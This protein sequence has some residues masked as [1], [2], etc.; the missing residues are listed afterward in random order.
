MPIPA[1]GLVPLDDRPCNRL[2]PTQL[3]GLVGLEVTLP[4]RESLGWFTQPGDS[5]AV[6]AWV[7]QC[8][9]QH[10]VLSLDMLCYGGL[11]AARS[12]HT[13]PAA[14]NARL[15]G[16]RALKQQRPDLV[17]YA[18]NCLPRLGLTVASAGDLRAHEDLIAYAMLADRVERLGEDEARPE[19]EAVT[20]R[21]DP[22][23]LASYLGVR[24]RNHEVSR[25]ALQLTADGVFD[26]LALVQEDAAPVGLHMGEQEALRAEVERLG[27]GDRVAIHP[28]ADEVGLVLMARHCNLNAGR[29]ARVCADYATEAGSKVIPL[30]EDRPLRETVLSTL[31]AAGAEAAPPMRADAILFVHTPIGAQHESIEAPP[32]GQSPTVAMQADSVAERIGFAAEAGCITGLADLVYANGGDP[33]MVAALARN[34]AGQKLRAY[35]G[36]NTSSNTVGAAVAQLC[37]EAI[38][39]REKRDVAALSRAFLACRL[40]DDYAYQTLVRP[41]A[42]EKAAAAGLDQFAMGDAAGPLEEYVRAELTSLAATLLPSVMGVA[43]AALGA[44]RISLPWRRLFEVEVEITPAR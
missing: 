26:Y 24:R 5:D 11:V 12:P 4:T 19:L 8:P 29:A 22:A 44:L 10:L 13:D 35:S 6:A 32:Q 34:G 1:L 38:A 40:L 7:Q 43:P 14:A 27:I 18:S 33:E 3:A 17:I 28:G 16:L 25:A 21:L 39:A 42:V 30:Y 23:L 20:A 41:K 31:Q 2:F 9:A 37:L 36:W 15:E